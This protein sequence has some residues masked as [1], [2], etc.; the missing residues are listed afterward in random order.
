MF[1][2]LALLFLLATPSLTARAT[3]DSHLLRALGPQGVNL[4]RLRSSATVRTPGLVVQ[5]YD[6][7][8]VRPAAAEDS[9]G[10][11]P[12]WFTQPLDH[13][14]NLSSTFGQRFW[15]NSRHYRP[16]VGGPVYVL[17]AGETSGED[18]LPFLDTGIMDIL[19]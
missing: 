15:V 18:R 10:F 1:K 7:I 5:D 4:W 2:R 11:S 12:Q 6:N 3:L 13:F 9:L 8:A 14:S 19:A 17:D 16:N